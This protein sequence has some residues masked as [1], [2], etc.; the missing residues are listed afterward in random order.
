MVALYKVNV[1]GTELVEFMIFIFPVFDFLI[2][3]LDGILEL[4][5]SIG[6]SKIIIVGILEF[7]VPW[8]W[9]VIASMSV[10]YHLSDGL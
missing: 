10:V 7:K 2:E 9:E 1:G 6:K 8:K 5:D 3:F 4:I